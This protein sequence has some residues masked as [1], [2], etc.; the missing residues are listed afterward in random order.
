MRRSFR[1][2]SALLILLPCL[3]AQF[4]SGIQG[5]IVDSTGAVIPNVQVIVTNVATGVTRE[6]LTS[7]LGIF[8]VLSLGAGTYSVKATKEG[9][10]AAEQVSVELAANEIRKVDF[11][12]KVSGLAETVNVGA[13]VEALETEQG[14]ISARITSAQL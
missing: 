9:F 10:S 11:G 14:R 13:Q 7:D 8:R 6:V 1:L 2:V 4:G 3:F 5:T 12:M